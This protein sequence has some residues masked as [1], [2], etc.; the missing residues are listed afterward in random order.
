MSERPTIERMRVIQRSA[1]P[2]GALLLAT[3]I[4]VSATPQD[5]AVLTWNAVMQRAIAT[6]VPPVAG[7]F[8]ARLYAIMHSAIFDA[9]NGIERRY[10]PIH[11]EPNAPRGASKRAAA[12][13][14]AYTALVTLFPAQVDAFEQDLQASLDQVSAGPSQDNSVSIA[15]GRLWGEQ[16]ALEILAWREADGL[17]PPGAPYLGSTAVGKWR[18]TPPAFAP[19]LA[20]TMATTDPFV[21]ES[22]WSFRS[23]TGPPPLTSQEY[24]DSVNEVQLVGSATSTTR[25]ADQTEAARFWFG[26]APA[27]WNRAAATASR[28]RNLTLSE[29]ARLFAVVTIAQADAIISCWDAKYFFELWRPITAIT[30]ADTDGNP[31]TV[32]D[33]TWTPLFA[34]PPYP[35][36]DSGHQSVSRAS[37]TV[38][39]AYVGDDLPFEGF[40]ENFP[41][42][43]RSYANFT[44]AADE[45]SMARIWAGI[46]FRFSMEDT[47]TRATQVAHYVLDNAAQPVKGRHTG[48]LPN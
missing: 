36:Y 6:S 23:L 26:T 42:V 24:A 34:S 46:H 31:D 22:P 21:I 47:Q 38:L 41:G 8:Q 4:G 43:T 45:A 25:T 19:G 2:L 15:R 13:Q 7:V 29:N 16:V 32:A 5:D 37:A 1:V 48:Q 35:E 40:S 20:P 30:L 14:A 44:A 28:A 9:V 11:V 3:T 33:P 10:T 12:I 17:N 18:P 27:F 39:I